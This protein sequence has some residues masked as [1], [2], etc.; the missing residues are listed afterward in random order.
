M[1]KKEMFKKRGNNVTKTKMM[2]HKEINTRYQAFAMD[3]SS[4]GGITL[5]ALVVTIVVLI[6]LATI[7]IYA[8]LR[9]KWNYSKSGKSKSNTLTS[10]IK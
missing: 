8:V 7:S 10:K 3:K 4:I 6:I 9:R 5:I 2:N 1:E